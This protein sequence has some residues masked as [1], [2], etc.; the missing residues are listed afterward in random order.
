M[1]CDGST[2]CTSTEHLRLT[3]SVKVFNDTTQGGWEEPQLVGV[4]AVELNQN[5]SAE[6]ISVY[7]SQTVS[8]YTGE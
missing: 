5:N 7:D 6:L 1:N 4:L 8:L 2:E 3:G